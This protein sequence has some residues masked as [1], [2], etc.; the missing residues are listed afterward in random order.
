MAGQ[1]APEV[2]RLLAA[3]LGQWHVGPPGVPAQ[4]GP[5][6]LAVANE[7][8]LVVGVGRWHRPARICHRQADPRSASGTAVAPGSA[9]KNSRDRQ[10]KTGASIAP[11]N[12]EIRVL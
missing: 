9:A 11:G 2:E 7:P 5:F 8:E 1:P 6:G 4:P 10:P 12:C 3:G